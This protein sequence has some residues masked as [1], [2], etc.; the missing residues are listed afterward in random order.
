ML[1]A[2]PALICTQEP[3]L[4]ERSNPVNASQH[5]VGRLATAQRNSAVVVFD[6]TQKP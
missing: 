4:E 1:T 3:A 5:R 2:D 6:D